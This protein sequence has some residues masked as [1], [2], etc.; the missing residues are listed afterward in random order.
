MA[1]SL[2]DGS[3]VRIQD[4]KEVMVY[5]YGDCHYLE[6]Q[7]M[8]EGLGIKVFDCALGTLGLGFVRR[9]AKGLSLSG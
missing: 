3:K 8:I 2:L 6:I 5:G 9:E 4:L 1:I 7:K